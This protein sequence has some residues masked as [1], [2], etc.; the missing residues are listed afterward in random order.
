MIVKM[1]KVEGMSCGGCVA[2][3]KTAL[4]TVPE[5]IEAQVQLKAPEAII[6]MH[7]DAGITKLQEALA[8]TG[9]YRISEMAEGEE[10]KAVS[11]KKSM[12]GFLSPKKD[13]CK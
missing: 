9:H 3:V 12:L 8:A 11:E 5:V 2:A 1:Y 7:T 10:K 4:K 6:S 13:C